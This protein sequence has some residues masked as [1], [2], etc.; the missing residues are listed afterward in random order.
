MDEVMSFVQMIVW[1]KGGLGMGWHYR[2]NYETV[3]VARKR[4]PGAMLWNGGN[5][6]ANVIRIS[7]IKPSADDHPTPKPV[8]LMSRFIQWHTNPGGLVLDPFM[9]AGP[10]LEAAKALGRRAIGIDVDER[11]CEKAAIRASQEVLGL[12]G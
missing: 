1:D 10:T 2:R 12:V 7:G 3:L 5:K 4:G 6:T 8:G 11:W 9:G